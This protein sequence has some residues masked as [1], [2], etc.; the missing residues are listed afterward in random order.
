M[1][2][3]TDQLIKGAKIKGYVKNDYTEGKEFTG[4]FVAQIDKG[5]VTIVD[6][7]PGLYNPTIK[8]TVDILEG[9]IR[10]LEENINDLYHDKVDLNTDLGNVDL[11]LNNIKPVSYTHLTL[12]TN[13]EV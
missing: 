9:E 2:T 13:R 3:M 10:M 11:E 12:P 5:N 8:G 7:F 1:A 4:I 6:K